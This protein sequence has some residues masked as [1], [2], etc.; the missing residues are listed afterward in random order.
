MKNDAQTC[1]Q[2][3][4]AHKAAQGPVTVNYKTAFQATGMDRSTGP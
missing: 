3:G 1:G 2:P 4:L